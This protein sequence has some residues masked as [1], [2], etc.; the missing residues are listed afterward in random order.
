MKYAYP[1]AIVLFTIFVANIIVGKISMVF[2]DMQLPLGFGGVIE[3]L[4]MCAAC[5]FLVIGFVRSERLN[6]NNK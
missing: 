4:L 3:F 6:K 5:A 1:I 2:W